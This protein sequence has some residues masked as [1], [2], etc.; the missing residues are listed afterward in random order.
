MGTSKLKQ[1]ISLVGLRPSAQPS[2]VLSGYGCVWLCF[3]H[4][5]VMETLAMRKQRPPIK[6]N[7]ASESSQQHVCYVTQLCPTYSRCRC[8]SCFTHK[9]LQTPSTESQRRLTAN[10]TAAP[11]FTWNRK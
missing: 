11:P 6:I 1:V 4:L 10:L 5:S 7:R 3:T 2:S 8:T 9:Q